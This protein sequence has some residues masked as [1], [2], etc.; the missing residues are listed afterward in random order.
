[1]IQRK[2]TTF[3]GQGYEPARKRQYSR[4][5]TAQVYQPRQYSKGEWKYLDVTVNQALNSTPFF[6]LLN[7]LVPGTGASQRV[8]MK[9][10][11]MS[12]QANFRVVTTAATGVDQYC[13]YMIVLDRQPNGLAPAAIT[14]ILNISSVNGLKNLASRKRFN[15]MIDKHFAMGSTLNDATHP[16]S[17]PNI[18]LYRIYMKL[19]RPLVIEYNT[20]TAGTVADISTNS[21]HLVGIGSV[22][23][24]ATDCQLSGYVRVRYIDF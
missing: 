1:M 6:Q 21:I 23:A 9:V 3:Y 2:R 11:V 15:L 17:I 7:G 24:G 14:D 22:A 13:R 8:G 16:G 5:V 12:I 19:R 20:G 10:T 4:N 18:R